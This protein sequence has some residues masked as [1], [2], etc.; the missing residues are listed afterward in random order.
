MRKWLIAKSFL[1]ALGLGLAAG[2]SPDAS[3]TAGP[4]PAPPSIL[5]VTLDTTRADSVG[6]ES[7]AA[8][9]PNLDR[10]AARGVRFAHAYATAPETLPSHASMLTGLYPPEH[11]VHVNADALAAGTP[12]LAE[13]L[14]ARGY[15]TAAFVSG[16]PLGRRFGLAR[17]F[18]LYDDD[19]GHGAA[20]RPAVATAG[21]ALEWLGRGAAGPVF[22][23]VHFYDPHEPYEPPEP[24]RSRFPD[25]P[26]LGEIAAMDR[27]LGRLLDGFGARAG[28]GAVRVLVAGDHG[29]GLGEHGELRHGDLLYQGAMRV[30]LVAA[31]DGIAA[32][33]VVDHPVSV[34]RV[35]GTVLAWAGEGRP[36]GLVPL[37]GAPPETVLGEA[38]R[39]L[40]HYGWQPQVM[41]I[42]G[43][44]KVIHAGG[45]EIYDLAA[46]PAEAHDLAGRA[47]LPAELRRAL[48][49]YPLPADD[50]DGGPAFAGE[51]LEAL[52]SL[53]YVGWQGRAPRRDDAPRPRDMTHLFDDLELGSSLFVR[54][55]YRLAIPVF[56]RVFEEDPYNLMIALRLAVAHSGL[57]HD[58]E[59]LVWFQ[60]ARGIA[61][62]SSDVDH[63]LAL[64]HLSAGRPAEAEPLLERVLAASPDRL[65]AL[66]AL[67][68]IRERQGRTGDAIRLLERAVA[69]EPR[70]AAN[71]VRLGDLRMARGDTAA[72]IVAFERARDLQDD[73]F[74]RH[75]E[76]GVLYLA[77]RRLAEAAESL[78][79]VPPD[80]PG[81]PMALFK[82]AQVGVLLGEP[83]RARRVRL[84]AERADPTTRELIENEP[85][86]RDLR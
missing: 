70:P 44:T 29:E 56:A 61:P 65:P 16:A 19:F 43:S 33:G 80:H 51:D 24:F 36:G 14:R 68:G 8:E 32:G 15:A 69:L 30:P 13:R 34:R 23:W 49:D 10:L 60:R 57:G 2:C 11:G 20:E 83:D 45:F 76:L 9:T 63:Y 18:D 40:L 73:A 25:D 5:L 35:F 85:L 86:F 62:G 48:R 17:G 82:R 47:E 50:P 55:E 72:A 41:A 79:R 67:A 64:H 58:L 39:P 27:E 42:A 37:P 26:Y 54:G 74:P 21:R 28:S 12:L 78:D 31:G 53:G 59:A 71:L 84:A 66:E 3:E 38:M 46:D 1:W 6:F 4:P 52:A 75:L 81:Y 22:L 77:A 7:A